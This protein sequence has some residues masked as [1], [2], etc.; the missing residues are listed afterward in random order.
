[1]N[2]P[3]NPKSNLKLPSVLKFSKLFPEVPN[4]T[5]KAR[6]VAPFLGPKRFFSGVSSDGYH[7]NSNCRRTP[8]METLKGLCVEF[9]ILFRR[10]SF[11]LRILI[12]VVTISVCSSAWADTEAHRQAAEQ[13]LKLSNA[14]RML[15]PMIRQMQQGTIWKI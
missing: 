7:Y 6:F 4:P 8:H 10:G 9:D 5:F 13:V 1:M 3:R 2:T 12:T 11:G 14:H 15:E